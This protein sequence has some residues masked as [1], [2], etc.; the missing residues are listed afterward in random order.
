MKKIIT[1]ASFLLIGGGFWGS[2]RG[3]S[4]YNIGKIKFGKTEYSIV[5]PGNKFL[6]PNPNHFI[7]F[8]GENIEEIMDNKKVKKYNDRNI[9]IDYIQKT[10]SVS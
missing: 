1:L 8:V 4:I 10:I 9:V 5:M 3:P 6:I 2:A 7:A